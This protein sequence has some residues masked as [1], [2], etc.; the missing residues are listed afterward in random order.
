M[1]EAIEERLRRAVL[2]AVEQQL[3]DNQP[4]VTRQTFARLIKEG[5]AED[6]AKKM[7]GYVVAA[8]VFGVLREGRRYSERSFTAKLHA[9]PR[10]PW[11][12]AEAGDETDS[13]NS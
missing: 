13:G 3:R 10:P 4:P 2:Q 5:F 1:T 8:E 11:E 6:E 9:L 7:I 12:G